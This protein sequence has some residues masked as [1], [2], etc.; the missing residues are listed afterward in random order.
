L[1]TE[2]D[3]SAVVFKILSPPYP[4]PAYLKKSVSPNKPAAGPKSSS[5]S[6]IPF[7]TILQ[8]KKH[9]C[10]PQNIRQNSSSSARNLFAEKYIHVALM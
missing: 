2:K 7:A 1:S 5:K 8:T 4:S 3:Q 9:P 10:Q 6:L